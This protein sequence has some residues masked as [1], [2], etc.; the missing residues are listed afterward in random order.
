MSPM[1]DTTDTPSTGTPS[2]GTPSTATPTT[3]SAA[4]GAGVTWHA[5]GEYSDIRYET[6]DDGI[7][8]IMIC[9]P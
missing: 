5:S 1:T 9:R 8:K 2:T 3:G 6:T 7:A 4:L